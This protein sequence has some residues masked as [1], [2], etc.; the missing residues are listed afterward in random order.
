MRL[1]RLFKLYWN[2]IT[3]NIY[4]YDIDYYEMKGFLKKKFPK[5]YIEVTDLHKKTC[6]Y[7]MLKALVN[8]CP[9]KHL[10]YKK[11]VHD[12][13]DFSFEALGFFKFLFPR[14]AI[15]LCL[16]DTN[17][18]KHATLCGLTKTKRGNLSFVFIEPQANKVFYTNWKPYTIIL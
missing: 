11:E 14:L 2:R 6:N 5:C 3:K 17:K 7:K 10:E 13:E 1:I 12:C 4:Q 8:L 9:V 16:C 18:G 15:G